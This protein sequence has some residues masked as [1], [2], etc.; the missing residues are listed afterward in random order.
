MHGFECLKFVDVLEGLPFLVIS[1]LNRSIV[2]SEISRLFCVCLAVSKD[3]VVAQRERIERLDAE[4]HGLRGQLEELDDKHAITDRHVE[5][6]TLRFFNQLTKDLR[7]LFTTHS[8]REA[9][10]YQAAAGVWTAALEQ[11]DQA[12][13]DAKA[14]TPS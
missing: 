13:V 5:A 6:E 12:L 2:F 9:K 7:Q 11:L 4:I 14:T 8:A 3:P 1:G 10:R